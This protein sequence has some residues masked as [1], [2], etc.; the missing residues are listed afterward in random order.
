MRRREDE[1]GLYL[2]D[3]VV[4]E[5][6]TGDQTEYRYTRKG[7]Y[8]EGCSPETEVWLTYYKDGVAVNGE[9]GARLEGEQ[10]KMLL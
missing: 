5:P 10:W 2:L 1:R 7:Q 8:P 9:V 3:L 6:G 4:S